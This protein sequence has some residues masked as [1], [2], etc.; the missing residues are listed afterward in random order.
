M[1]TEE[2]SLR[3][4][5][6]DQLLLLQDSLEPCLVP[7]IIEELLGAKLV[8][9]PSSS[10]DIPSSSVVAGEVVEGCICA[11]SP[12]IVSASMVAYE[13]AAAQI[14]SSPSQVPEARSPSIQV[15]TS[16]CTLSV[17]WLGQVAPP[18]RWQA[19]LA[20]R[21]RRRPFSHRLLLS[22][23]RLPM[24]LSRRCLGRRW[25]CSSRPQRGGTSFLT[26]PG[27]C[28]RVSCGLLRPVRGAAV[29]VLCSPNRRHK[30]S[31]LELSSCM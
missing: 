24:K 15:V 1:S 13:T 29:E 30:F 3:E 4:F 22:R 23:C 20:M 2:L 21:G 27:H 25:S 8:A 9:P 16:P 28:F 14:L 5:L 11:P 18:S 7:H 12:P 26:T 31:S 10:E 6:L 19:C 17:R